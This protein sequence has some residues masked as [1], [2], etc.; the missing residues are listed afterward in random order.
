MTGDQMRD[1]LKLCADLLDHAAGMLRK[2][3]EQSE[4]NRT[5]DEIVEAEQNRERNAHE[6]HQDQD[7]G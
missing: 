4:T 2:V 3:I 1:Q 5:F 7:E 6:E